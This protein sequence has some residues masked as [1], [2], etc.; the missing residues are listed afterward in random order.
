M[1]SALTHPP[2]PHLWNSWVCPTL[3]KL[4]AKGDRHLWLEICDHRVWSDGTEDLDIWACRS[5]GGD[6]ALGGAGCTERLEC[7]VGLMFL[8]LPIWCGGKGVPW[9]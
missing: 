7:Q 3:L 2:N 1:H 9:R 6:P 8:S 5:L 4:Q